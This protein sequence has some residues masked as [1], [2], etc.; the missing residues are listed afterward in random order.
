ML[1][2]RFPDRV[3]IEY[4]RAKAEPLEPG[5]EHDEVLRLAGRVMA[6]RDMGKLVFLDLVDMSGRIQLMCR[7]ERTGPI[8][9]DLGDVV[10][11]AGKPAKTRRGEPS[12]AVDELRLVAKI[13]RTLPDTYHGLVDA[14]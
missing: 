12:L 14:E 1:P 6:R 5:G 9:L 13:Q 11:V 7:E 3:E 4:A 10:G 8:D 2:K